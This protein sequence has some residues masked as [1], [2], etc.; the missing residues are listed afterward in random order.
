MDAID[1]VI[2]CSARNIHLRE[3]HFNLKKKYIYITWSVIIAKT[4][5][6]V[7]YVTEVYVMYVTENYFLCDVCDWSSKISMCV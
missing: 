3:Y 6:Y 5:F 2:D 4:T 7:M 1:V